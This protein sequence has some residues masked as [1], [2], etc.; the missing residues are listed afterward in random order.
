MGRLLCLS[1]RQIRRVEA[2]PHRCPHPASVELLRVWLH[3]PEIQRRLRLAGVATP[4]PEELL[5]L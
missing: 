4:F 3:D 2:E 5:E 1:E